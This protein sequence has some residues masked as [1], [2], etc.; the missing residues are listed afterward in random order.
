M[1]FV[2][3]FSQDGHAG[4]ATISYSIDDRELALGQGALLA[5]GNDRVTVSEA[6]AGGQGTI[7]EWL[8]GEERPPQ[9]K[10]IRRTYSVLDWRESLRNSGLKQ[11]S[12]FFIDPD[13]GK[14]GAT[15]VELAPGSVPFF[16]AM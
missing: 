8:Y 1:F 7:R 10:T 9:H 2:H 11:V 4:S 16:R 6:Y 12:G 5:R 3:A 14:L 15:C 13:T